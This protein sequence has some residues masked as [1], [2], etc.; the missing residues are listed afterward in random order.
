[1]G[2]KPPETTA[3]HGVVYLRMVPN[4]VRNA[5]RMQCAARNR[6]QHEVLVQ[7]MRCIAR[8]TMDFPPIHEKAKHVRRGDASYQENAV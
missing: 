6:G 1:M 5:F 2:K 8:G 4:A 3:T 7:Y